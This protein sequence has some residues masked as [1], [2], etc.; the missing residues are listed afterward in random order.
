MNGGSVNKDGTPMR[1][2]RIG[3]ERELPVGTV[4]NLLDG[5]KKSS[6][7]YDYFIERGVF[8]L[9]WKTK[10]PN[11]QR[12]TWFA[13]PTLRESMECPKCLTSFT[14]AGN[15]EQSGN[16]WYYRTA[17]PFSVPNYADGA[18]AVLL[19]LDALG[20]RM[21]SSLRTTSVPSFVATSPEKPNLEADLAMFWKDSLH[22]EDVEG[23]LFGECKTY[24]L[25][26]VK[27]FKRMQYLAN[28]FPGAIL[29]FSTLRES[30]TKREIT[31]LTRLTK[32][33]RK[34]WKSERPINPVLILTGNELL[35]AKRPPY[36]WEESMRK[37]FSHMHDL[38]SLCDATQQIY[39][40]LPSW[41]EDWHRDSERRRVRREARSAAKR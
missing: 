38:L 25:F 33:G 22:G 12:S 36:C 13:L 9:G 27:D 15:I 30:L 20:D 19:T 34:Y 8:K 23:L 35:T 24:G 3:G 5:S 4:K 18:F 21:F 11:C 26:E 16:G 41:F 29:V 32:A 1:G 31:A 7:R 28:S 40:R 10:C 2:N 14:A 6:F 37:R 17:G 39:L